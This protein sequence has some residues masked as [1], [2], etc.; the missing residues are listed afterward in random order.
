MN[1]K[2]ELE[3]ELWQSGFY[4]NT[5]M[6]LDRVR[7]SQEGVQAMLSISSLNY[8]SV[9]FGK[10]SNVVAHMVYTVKPDTP[11]FFL[12]SSETYIIHNYIDVID[13]FMG[14]WPI[15]L[16]IVQTNHA[17]MDIRADID[18]LS[19]RQPTIKWVLRPPGDPGWDWGQT[20]QA[21]HMDLQTMVEREKYTG[22]FWGLAKEE[23]KARRITLSTTWQG[24]PH[25]SIFRYS[26]GKYRC[27]PLR[28][29]QNLDIAAY[30]LAHDIPFLDT[31]HQSGLGARTTARITGR[32]AEEGAM[33]LMHHHN[34]GKTN[35][36]YERFPELRMYR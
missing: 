22:W 19:S 8:V 25:L 30:S 36:L 6:H 24:Q 2:S 23:S 28:N 17:A 14:R 1:Q 20:R 32:S 21:G 29:W 11:M 31:Y 3:K 13:A 16:T 5:R 35:Q 4:K 15:N 33:A 10:Q 18:E 26:D 12:A 27:C 9:S 7:F 34:L